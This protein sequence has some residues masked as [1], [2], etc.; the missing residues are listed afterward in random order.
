MGDADKAAPVRAL[1]AER[2]I[3]YRKDVRRRPGARLVS[4]AG[5]DLTFDT[6][7]GETLVPVVCRHRGVRAGGD[8]VADRA[9]DANAHK[10]ARTRNLGLHYELMLTPDVPRPARGAR[11]PARDPGRG[12]APDRAGQAHGARQ[13]DPAAR[14]S[15]PRAHQRIGAGHHR[16]DRSCRPNSRREQA[17]PGSRS[18]SHFTEA[19]PRLCRGTRNGLTYA[20]V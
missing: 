4:G 15:R 3:E 1:G 8:A 6:V 18:N 12:R 20:A 13:R 10:V 9:V 14:A 16:Q 2:L 17:E 7:G 11:A 19:S 5:V